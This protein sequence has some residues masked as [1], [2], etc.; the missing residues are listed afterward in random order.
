MKYD[1]VIFWCTVGMCFGAMAYGVIGMG[2]GIVFGLLIG[3]S[4]TK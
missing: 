2:I 3:L 1:A 4:I